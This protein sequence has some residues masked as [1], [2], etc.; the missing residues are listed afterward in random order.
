M[1][2]RP[3][4]GRDERVD[5]ERGVSDRYLPVSALE[6]LRDWFTH[7]ILETD[8]KYGGYLSSVKG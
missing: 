1:N 7:H 3:Q 2:R 6:F 8:K 5:L 4:G